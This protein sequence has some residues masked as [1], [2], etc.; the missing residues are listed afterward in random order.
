MVMNLRRTAVKLVGGLDWLKGWVAVA[1]RHVGLYECR[2]VWAASR[3]LI[4]QER[5]TRMGALSLIQYIGGLFGLQFLQPASRSRWRVTSS[6]S[7]CKVV[8]ITMPTSA[9]ELPSQAGRK[10]GLKSPTCT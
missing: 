4:R 8:I 7:R 5:V 9:N 6:S 10:R 1:T 3:H 2:E